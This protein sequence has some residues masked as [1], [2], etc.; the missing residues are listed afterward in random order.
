MSNISKFFLDAQRFIDENQVGKSV[1]ALCVEQREREKIFEEFKN[2]V[3]MERSLSSLEKRR[4]FVNWYV[5]KYQSLKNTNELI[6]DL[7][8]LLFVSRRTIELI[9]SGYR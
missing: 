2:E 6:D 4:I 8:E 3:T 7:M 9:M 5:E 1:E